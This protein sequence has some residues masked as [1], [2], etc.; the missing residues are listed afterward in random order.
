MYT[1]N[2]YSGIIVGLLIFALTFTEKNPTVNICSVCRVA[3]QDRSF[4]HE[5]PFR[6]AAQIDQVYD[7]YR[8]YA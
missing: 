5:I 7:C 6:K 4:W 8:F 3:Q 2:I 1:V